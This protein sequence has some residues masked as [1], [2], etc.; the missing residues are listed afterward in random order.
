L[1]F[2]QLACIVKRGQGAKY[3]RGYRRQE[4]KV[5]PVTAQKRNLGTWPKW[6]FPSLRISVKIMELEDRKK[7]WV[8]NN[9]HLW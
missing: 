4:E 1:Q 9:Q 6:V 2:G 8:P 5:Y 7:F 3:I